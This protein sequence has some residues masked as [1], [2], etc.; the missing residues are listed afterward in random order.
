MSKKHRRGVAPNKNGD[1]SAANAPQ[2]DTELRERLHKELKDELVKKQISNAENFDRSVLTLSTS[3]LGFSVIFIKDFA[4]LASA[5]AR[6]MLPLSWCLFGGAVVFTV[7]S[8][9]TSQEAIRHQLS[10]SERY[11]I[12]REAGAIEEKYWP[13]SWTTRLNYAAGS[14]LVVGMILTV[15]FAIFNLPTK[16]MSLPNIPSAPAPV[17]SAPVQPISIAQP[18]V[19]AITAGQPTNQIRPVPTN[20]GK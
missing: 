5:H 20:T 8:F 4:P 16:T 9:M 11:Y 10:V 13:A 3:A 7:V 15:A 14:S 6:W 2:D 19:G 18:A 1:P 17:P 12:N